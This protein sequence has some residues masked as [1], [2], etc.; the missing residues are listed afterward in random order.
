MILS[1]S[2]LFPKLNSSILHHMLSHW[3]RGLPHYHLRHRSEQQLS[4]HDEFY[5]LFQDMQCLNLCKEICINELKHVKVRNM[6]TQL[7]TLKRHKKCWQHNCRETSASW[8][9]FVMVNFVFN[10][11]FSG[12][13]F[14]ISLRELFVFKISLFLFLIRNHHNGTFRSYHGSFPFSYGIST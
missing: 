14:G 10:T 6:F 8:K 7:Y 11:H 2:L 3:S 12:W 5:L 1:M 9:K 4:L 13:V